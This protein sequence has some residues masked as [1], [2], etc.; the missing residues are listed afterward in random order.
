[1]A[2]SLLAGLFASFTE[3]YHIKLILKA[4]LKLIMV[5]HAFGTIKYNDFLG[6]E[7]ILI[8]SY[9]VNPRPARY[10]ARLSQNSK[11]GGGG[12]GGAL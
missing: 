12:W 5:V 10:K 3:L 1:M 11:H 2:I 4:F 6:L 7:T 9:T 8:L